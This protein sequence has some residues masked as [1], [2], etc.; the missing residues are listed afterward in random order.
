LIPV[1]AGTEH[2]IGNYYYMLA[3]QSRPHQHQKL[4][5]S[6]ATRS[7]RANDMR[8]NCPFQTRLPFVS[9]TNGLSWFGHRI[10]ITMYVARP[11]RDK[12][13]RK[14]ERK[15]KGHSG[16]SMCSVAGDTFSGA[17]SS[18]SAA[19]SVRMPAVH[20]PAPVIQAAARL[21]KPGCTG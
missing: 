4:N 14:K 17:A 16:C 3:Q 5:S 19:G 12:E 8:S 15:K 11:R 21:P 9:Q 20:C 6:A 2:G 10:M 13:E 7:V 18:C 1:A